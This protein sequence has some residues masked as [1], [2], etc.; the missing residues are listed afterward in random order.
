MK[1]E[2][3]EPD[4][5]VHALV[6]QYAL[7]HVSRVDPLP[8]AHRYRGPRRR[9]EHRAAAA[10]ALSAEIASKYEVQKWKTIGAQIAAAR[11]KVAEAELTLKRVAA[12]KQLLEE[13]P[14]PD[15]ANK[16]LAITQRRE[17]AITARA[18]AEAELEVLHRVDVAGFWCEAANSIRGTVRTAG[19]TLVI[20]LSEKRERVSTALNEAAEKVRRILHDAIA[21]YIT[22]LLGDERAIAFAQ[23]DA[24][25]NLTALLDA[26]RIEHIGA[27]PAGAQESNA[28]PYRGSFEKVPLPSPPPPPPV[29]EYGGEPPARGRCGPHRDDAAASRAE[30]ARTDRTHHRRG[31]FPRPYHKEDSQCQH[32]ATPAR[33]MINWSASSFR[34]AMKSCA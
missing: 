29:V 34:P 28:T 14:E 3:P 20:A 16:L 7:A 33:V 1:H 13:N 18:A 32:S 15:L 17:A 23:R 31:T 19:T 24:E 4:V 30:V 27:M 2:N 6:D 22:P 10:K 11:A 8:I 9:A 5:R 12:A 25:K 26:L 21:E